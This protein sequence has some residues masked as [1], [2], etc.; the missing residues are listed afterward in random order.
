MKIQYVSKYLN[1]AE[2][3]LVPNLVCPMDQGLLFCNQ[4]LEE[5]IFLYCLICDY[6]NN[7]GSIL[8]AKIVEQVEKV[9]NE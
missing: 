8:Y 6:K 4:D 2:E 7:I 1:L 5:N 3:G 9:K